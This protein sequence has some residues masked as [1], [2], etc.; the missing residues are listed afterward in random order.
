MSTSLEITRKENYWIHMELEI[1][2]E[3]MAPKIIDIGS[4]SA[5]KY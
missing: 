2:L 5:V 3:T 4:E 1:S